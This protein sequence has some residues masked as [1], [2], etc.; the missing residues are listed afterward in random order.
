MRKMIS[1]CLAFTLAFSL[2]A[3]GN[4]NKAQET[5]SSKAPEQTE[6]A[7]E[8][9]QTDGISVADF[10][11]DSYTKIPADGPSVNL[12][13]GHAMQE[14]TAS[15]LM[16][17]EL[18]K[19]VETYSEGKINI[20]IYPNG[21]MGSDNEM[22]ASCVAGDIDLVYQSGSTHATFVP[23]TMIFDTPFLFTGYD[24]DKV[25]G[26]LTDSAFR[27]MYNEANEEGG[28]VCLMLRASDGMNLTANRAVAGLGDLKGLKIRTAQSE[29]R[30]AVWEAL[31]ANPT[32]LAFNELY[33]A[34]QNGTVEAQDN[35]L[36]NAVNSALYEVQDYLILTRHMM[37]SYDL[38]MNKDKFYAMPEEYQQFLWEVCEDMSAYDYAVSRAL[39]ES[40]YETLAEKLEICEINDDLLAEMREAAAPAV[41]SVKK[42]T[43]ND[44][45]YAVLDEL[46]NE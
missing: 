32:P 25:E 20:T 38:T 31:G 43:Q 4:S 39:E 8:E 22:I 34:L 24:A 29:S 12:V 26:I 45:M 10:L 19:A 6:A 2:T 13:L 7:A 30:M 11:S 36:Q 40:Y 1:G 3:C 5:Q 15:H 28:F 16:L 14:S 42:L 46:L 9:A 33:M 37:P 23:E 17:L 35:T 44:E 21:Q 27:D 41:E 18:K